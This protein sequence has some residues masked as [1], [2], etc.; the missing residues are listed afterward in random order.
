MAQSKRCKEIT[1]LR[2][3]IRDEEAQPLARLKAVE[4]LM[5]NHGATERNAATIRKCVK[6]LLLSSNPVIADRA[7]DVT[8]LLIGRLESKPATKI[9]RSLMDPTA[10][11]DDDSPYPRSQPLP[12]RKYSRRLVIPQPDPDNYVAGDCS[13]QVYVDRLKAFQSTATRRDRLR[14]ALDLRDDQTIDPA[15]LGTLY[16]ATMHEAFDDGVSELLGVILNYA[17]S[18]PGIRLPRATVPLLQELERRS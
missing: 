7:A 8:A 5:T 14:A 11:P 15:K 3:L 2:R 9:L 18:T 1:D 6:T 12:L 13:L 10:D 4:T 17:N 16:L